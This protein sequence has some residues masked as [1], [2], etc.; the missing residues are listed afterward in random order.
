[1]ICTIPVKIDDNMLLVVTEFEHVPEQKQTFNFEYLPEYFEAVDGY[2]VDI[3][4]NEL[5]RRLFWDCLEENEM[6]IVRLIK[7]WFFKGDY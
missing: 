2:L 4:N 5:P 6:K 1:M 7:E 3:N